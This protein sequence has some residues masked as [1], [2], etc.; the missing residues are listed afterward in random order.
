MVVTNHFEVQL[1]SAEDENNTPFKEHRKGNTTYV[2]VEPGVEYF[3]SITKVRT[4]TTC[5]LSYV[6]VDGKDLGY[7]TPWP[8]TG[9][10][11]SP[12]LKGICSLSNGIRTQ[13]ALQFVKASFVSGDSQIGSTMAGMGE[14]TIDVYEGTPSGYHMPSDWHSDAPFEASSIR[15][16]ENAGVTMKKNI[17]SKEGRCERKQ[18]AS[19]CLNFVE[20]A[21][22][23]SIRL[24]YC[25]T[26]GLIAVGILP[27]PPLW[28]LQ[29]IL[30]PAQTTP[31][32][33]E[34]LEKLVRSVKRTRNGNEVIELWDDESDGA[35]GCRKPRATSF[36]RDLGLTSVPDRPD[37]FALPTQPAAFNIPI[38]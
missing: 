8:S 5:L 34:Q 26:P 24:F 37:Q 7:V 19:L 32:E 10:S 16:N 6:D 22:L 21:F 2:E 25:A 28:D 11:T 1:V 29:R 23:Y 33:K 17:R 3:I 31:A 30:E 35:D 15:S 4:S 12:S 20:G 36:R 9:Y 27:K 38:M 14:V 18:E 13:K